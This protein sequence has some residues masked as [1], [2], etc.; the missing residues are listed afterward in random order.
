MVKCALCHMFCVVAVSREFIFWGI[1][2]GIPL[3]HICGIAPQMLVGR[4][5]FR[6]TWIN[7]IAVECP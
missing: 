1:V 6:Y 5:G 7:C 4:I 3:W 2:Y